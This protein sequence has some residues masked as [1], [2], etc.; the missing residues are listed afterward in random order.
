MRLVRPGE[1]IFIV[2]GVAE[3]RRAQAR[4]RAPRLRSAAMDDRALVEQQLGRP[5]RAFRRVAARCPDGTPGGDRAVALRRRRRSVPDDLLPDLPAPRGGGR[6]TRGGGR[7]RA[8]ERGGR[9][10]PRA[11]GRPRARDGGAAADPP[12]ARRRQGRPGRRLV[13]R[14]GDR[15]QRQPAPAQV[16]AR[17]RGLRARAA[18]LPPR[19]ADPGRARPTLAAPQCCLR[20]GASD[21][22]GGGRER[23]A[24]MG[25]RAPAAARAGARGAAARAAARGRSTPSSRS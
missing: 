7:R 15:R 1:R 19:R 17:A 25:G 12:R 22:R 23:A 11:R 13:A 16:P 9:A 2:K 21:H 14:A 5:P 20:I 10:R 4:A 8:L 6:A 18:G 3:W 24:R